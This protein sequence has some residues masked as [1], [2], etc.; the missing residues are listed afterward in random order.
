MVL[1]TSLEL[2][3]E[4]DNSIDITQLS[5]LRNEAVYHS[6]MDMEARVNFVDRVN[7]A[8]HGNNAKLDTCYTYNKR[9][10]LLLYGRLRTERV[11]KQFA[12]I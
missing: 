3:I 10:I 1:A 12:G 11:K 5:A 2:S 4:S 7:G 9:G 8:R 6:P